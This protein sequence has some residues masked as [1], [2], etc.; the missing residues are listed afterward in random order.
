MRRALPILVVL[1]AVAG[2]GGGKSAKDTYAEQQIAGCAKVQKRV[3]AVP[4]PKAQAATAKRSKRADKAVF[5]YAIKIDRALMAGMVDLR[6]VSAPA[7]LLPTQKAWLAAVRKALRARL[8]LDT[9][10]VK[11]IQ[12][13]S[14]N[15]LKARRAAN[16]LA[17]ELGIANGCTLTY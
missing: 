4:R 10:P 15:E 16:R 3:A 6:A 17:G 7:K 2:C 5:Q 12:Q 13:A 9:A 1:L 11:K 14:R 8:A